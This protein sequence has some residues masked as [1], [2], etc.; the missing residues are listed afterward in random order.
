M[1]IHRENVQ[2]C[3]DDADHGLGIVA[4]APVTSKNLA[5]VKVGDNV[6]F[7]IPFDRQCTL[8]FDPFE[9]GMVREQ[10]VDK[11][12]VRCTQFCCL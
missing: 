5:V 11:W 2:K 9:D 12:K 1:L 4:D 8:I 3:C 6:T 7:T 10:Q